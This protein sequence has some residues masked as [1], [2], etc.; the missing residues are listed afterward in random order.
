MAPRVSP[1]ERGV[2]HVTNARWDAVDAAA[3]KTKHAFPRTAK[4]CGPGAPMLAL[5]FCGVTSVEVTVAKKPGHRGEH[6]VS[7][8]PLRR[9]SR[10]A[11]A[12]PVCS[13]A[14]SS[15]HF[16]HETAG[17]ARIRL[18]LRPLQCRSGEISENLGRIAPRE[19]AITPT[20]CR[21]RP[22]RRTIQYPRDCSDRTEAIAILPH[23]ERMDYF[24]ALLL[25]ITSRHWC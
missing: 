23:K 2:A 18:S 8:K 5:S 14:L 22:R 19:R 16:A 6:E 20:L 4:S 9:E 7:R 21:H 24:V 13:C 11:S 1:D 12:E 17:A 15:V 10:I 25:A 3:R